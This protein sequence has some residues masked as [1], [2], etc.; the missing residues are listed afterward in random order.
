[1]TRLMDTGRK[2]VLSQALKRYLDVN[3]DYGQTSDRAFFE[4]KERTLLHYA[5]SV[6]IP[7]CVH[8][9]DP[10]Q[11][12][13]DIQVAKA[14]NCSIGGHIAYPDP[15]HYGYEAMT[16]SED[17]LY[18]WILLQLGAFSALCRA[19]HV[20]M[21]HVRPHGA[22]YAQFI[23]NLEVAM[24]VGR[25][26]KQFDPWLVLVLPVSPISRTVQSELNIQVAEEVY[27]GKRV[28]AE[29]VLAM[30]RFEESISP[31]GGLDQVRQ[32]IATS[33]VA[34]DE[35]KTV[36]VPCKTLHVSSKL[37]GSMMIA[38]RVNAML[39]QPVALPLLP[40]GSSGWL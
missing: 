13:R 19:G 21:A 6:N 37:P 31:Q 22:L 9:N 18:A 40:A 30:D 38:E 34:T 17:E 15:V 10:A 8:D 5:S 27:L 33:S 14:A 3:T 26:V 4:G 23:T 35:G 16:L 11:A 32:I 20:E 12:L 36:K 7:C 39:G 2:T 24:T 28:N 25:A 29:G 1:M